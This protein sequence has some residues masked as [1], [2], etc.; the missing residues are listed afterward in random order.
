MAST[1]NGVACQAARGLPGATAAHVDFYKDSIAG[2]NY[3]QQA[4]LKRVKKV[5]NRV[6]QRSTGVYLVDRGGYNC[7]DCFICHPP[8]S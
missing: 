4:R 2:P 1:N 6:Q 7:R 5:P 8:P 3:V